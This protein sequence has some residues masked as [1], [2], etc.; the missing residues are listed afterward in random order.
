MQTP[1]NR[2]IALGFFD[3]VHLGHQA[4]LRKT[5]DRA[6]QLRLAAAVLA[7]DAHP[8][9]CI[10]GTAVPLLQTPDERA[11]KIHRLI[12]VTE[13]LP[14]FFDE[15]LRRMPWD[16]FL[17]MLIEQFGAR[18]LVCG[19]DF[20]FGYQGAGNAARLQAAATKLGIGCDIIAEVKQGGAAVHSSRI[21]TLLQKGNLQ[22][23][24]QFL[25]EPYRLTK[26]V[27][28]GR[29]IGRTLGAPTIN[30]HI[31]PAQLTL[32]HGVY[33]TRVL[34]ERPYCSVTNIGIRPTVAAEKLTRVMA[35]SFILDYNGD[36]YGQTLSVE[37]Y[38]HLRPEQ[39]FE[40]LKALR[41]QIHSDAAAVRGY[42]A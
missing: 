28:H 26:V 20:T 24:N 23:A 10:T 27:E 29:K 1:P 32:P 22:R 33:A 16:K 17:A 35:E 18:H 38:K 30:M 42:F 3:G 8:L 11:E 6:R 36:L 34:L 21:R 4:I 19:Q 12:G 7:F 5:A 39:K 13:H 25:G 2:V 9:T 41:E 31:P 40:S 14:L 15:I 37:F